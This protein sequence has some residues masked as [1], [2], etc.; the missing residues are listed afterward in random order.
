MKKLI[1]LVL[2][3]LLVFSLA[4]CQSETSPTAVEPPIDGLTWGM[5]AEEVK[6]ALVKK[7]LTESEIVF[8]ESDGVG[9]SQMQL[10]AKQCKTLKIDPIPGCPL[11]D[12]V[13]PVILFFL[14]D[15]DGDQHLAYAYAEVTAEKETDVAAQ[16]TKLYG[17]PIGENFWEV[18][19]RQVNI[20]NGAFDTEFIVEYHANKYVKEN[21]GNF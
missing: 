12:S 10:S 6:A 11:S 4:A 9:H 8:H 16:L 13:V 1:S 15:K 14:E 3:V 21:F 19:D 18:D 7:G 2:C 20:S 5:T 17:E